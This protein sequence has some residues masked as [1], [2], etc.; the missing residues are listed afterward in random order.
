MLL[1]ELNNSE[2]AI[3]Q[4]YSR[5]VHWGYWDDPARSTN[6]AEDL[7]SATEAMT[8][9]LCRL[10][11]ISEGDHV[12]DV[13][14]GFGGTLASLNERYGSVKLTGLNIDERQI[15]R[16]RQQVLPRGGNVVTFDVG[17]ACALPYAD[18]SFDRVIAVECIFEFPS[19]EGFLREAARVLKP[20]GVLALSDY[21]SAPAFLP[22]AWAAAMPWVE[23]VEGSGRFDVRVTSRRYRD[24][25]TRTGLTVVSERNITPH[26]VPTYDHL[27]RLALP[28]LAGVQVLGFKVMMSLL[29][30]WATTGL[31][32]YSLLSFR[33]PGPGEASLG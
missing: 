21:V 29:K 30:F 11:G 6:T 7:A 2:S 27:R 19:R 5:H 20:G 22:L 33:K 16:A 15:A 12:L 17:D 3:A 28:Q 32:K 23:K 18:N 13:G 31:L 9:Q 1:D 26:T 14:C 4:A 10:A 24:L 8:L 25:A